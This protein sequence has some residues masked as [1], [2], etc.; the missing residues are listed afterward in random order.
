MIV[1]L[2]KLPVDFDIVQQANQIDNVRSLG[3]L[4]RIAFEVPDGID[5]D[6]LETLIVKTAG[7][8]EIQL[9][10]ESL[11]ESLAIRLLNAGANQI[12]VD[13]V[14]VDSSLPDDRWRIA[15][16]RFSFVDTEAIR[17]H[18]KRGEDALVAASAL[19]GRS[20]LAEV[21]GSILTSDRPDGLWPTLIV[22]RLGVALG[23]AYSSFESLKLAFEDQ[24]GVY[25]SRSRSEIWRKGETSG[26]TQRLIGVRVDCD[27]DTLRFMVDQGPPGFCHKNTHTCFGFERNISEVVNRLE[28]RI[29]GADEKSFTKKLFDDPE[30]LRKK[31][32][33]EAQ[34]LSD[35]STAPEAAWEAADVIYFSLIAMMRNGATLPDVY[36][37]LAR[38]MQRVV[39]RKNKLES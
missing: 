2:I 28:S 34:E 39:R 4:G 21:L 30:M 13:R 37:E 32:L 20:S 18:W 33:E 1:P 24:I 27:L 11:D 26:A 19:Q 31:L 9:L 15:S 29:R 17:Q 14:L 38:R 7:A 16:N 10:F 35:A 12:L 36:T 25:Y 5:V 6:L 23:L 3:L 22:D 8:Y